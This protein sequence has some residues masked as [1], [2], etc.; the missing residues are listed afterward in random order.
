MKL[1]KHVMILLL[2]AVFTGCSSENKDI[3]WFLEKAEELSLLW[4]FHR[5]AM[6]GPGYIIGGAMYILPSDLASDV[7]SARTVV[8]AK[9]TRIRPIPLKLIGDPISVS[10]RRYIFCGQKFWVILYDTYEGTFYLKVSARKEVK[11]PVQITGKKGTA[12][13]EKD[14][15]R[16]YEGLGNE[17][18][19]PL[20]KLSFTRPYG[21]EVKP[22]LPPI[23]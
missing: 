8:N 19:I 9:D 3:K 23:R 17:Y 4:G 14:G 2:M 10:F 12:L 7:E 15:I 18:T 5:V 11:R 21:V 13:L 22:T 1:R 20:H 6:T 16:V